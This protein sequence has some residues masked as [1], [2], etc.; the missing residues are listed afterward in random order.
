V[1]IN[2]AVISI[3]RLAFLTLRLHPSG[4]VVLARKLVVSRAK[5]VVTATQLH[6]SVSTGGQRGNSALAGQR[7][8]R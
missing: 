7:A 6:L 3:T 1:G 4:K 2:W 5:H 8:R